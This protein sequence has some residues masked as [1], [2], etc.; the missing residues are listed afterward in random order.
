M[1]AGI[2]SQ[3]K[4]PVCINDQICFYRQRNAG[5]LFEQF[6]QMRQIDAVGMTFRLQFAL[7]ITQ[8]FQIKGHL[9]D[10]ESRCAGDKAIAAD[11]QCDRR[12]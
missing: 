8:T 6:L 10:I 7:L 9:I 2:V 12:R 11:L 5:Q 4:I 1:T 3:F